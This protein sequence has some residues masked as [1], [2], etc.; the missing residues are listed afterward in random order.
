MEC[1]ENIAAD[2]VGHKKQTM[3]YGLY[4]GGSGLKIMEKYLF[5]VS[6]CILD[7]IDII[8]DLLQVMFDS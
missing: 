6:Y 4:S 3:T 1:P 7:L 8:I 2:I 5:E